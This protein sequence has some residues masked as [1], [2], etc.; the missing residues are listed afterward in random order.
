MR[1]LYSPPSRVPNLHDARFRRNRLCPRWVFRNAWS[2]WGANFVSA[3]AGAGCAAILY[4]AIVTASGDAATDRLTA[5]TPLPRLGGI[6]ALQ[7]NVWLNT[8]QS[9]VF[10][11]NNHFVALAV[12]CAY[13][14]TK[15]RASSM[16]WGA[17]VCG[18]AMTNQHTFVLLVHHW[19]HG[20]CFVLVGE[21]ASSPHRTFS[22]YSSCLSLAYCSICLPDTYLR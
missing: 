1:S 18:L 17:L 6:L 15:V 20:P 14:W 2:A 16:P 7:R 22:V 5:G 11:L 21:W 8:I 19:Q 12:L 13:D 4:I 3:V 9:E 10:G